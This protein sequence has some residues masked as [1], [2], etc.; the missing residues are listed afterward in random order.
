MAPAAAN[1]Y[2]APPPSHTH[3]K[4]RG[5]R[6]CDTCGAIENPSLQKF[7]LC[8]GCM[9]TQYCSPECQ[10]SHWPSHKAI[11]QHTA[12]QM[13]G[14]KQQP[15]GPAYPDENLA[16]Y[17][18]KFTST[19]SSLLGWAGF[20]ALQ[21]KRLPANIRQNALLIEL[22]YNAHADSLYRFSV[23]NTH[24][25]PR[26]YVTSH[27]AL[28]A[29]DISRREER[30]RRSGGIGTLI[31]L[32]QCGGISQVMPVEVDPPSKISWDSRDDWAEVLRHFVESGRTDFKPISTTARGVVYG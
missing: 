13:S 16:K 5:Y 22:S 19:H 28:V 25:V 24:V 31:I 10:K 12:A 29:A 18:R 30:C 11:C 15:I 20:Q 27:D 26:T 2:S 8:G 14:A 4:Q 17:L 32:V 1:Y 3:H 7:R 23:A 9:T 6:I 21:L